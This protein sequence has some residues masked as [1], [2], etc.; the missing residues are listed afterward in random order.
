MKIHWR[1]AKKALISHRE[2]YIPFILVSML[3]VAICEIFWSMTQ[4]SSLKQ[5]AAGTNASYIILL[6]AIFVTVLSVIFLF[7]INRFLMKR[8][9]KELALY[10]MLGLTKGDLRLVVLYEI[11]ILWAMVVV[12][13][14][15]VGLVL[16]KLFF[17]ILTFFL[18]TTTIVEQFSLNSLILVTVIFSGIFSILF[19]SD[20]KSLYQVQPANLWNQSE[21][22]EPEPKSNWLLGVSSLLFLAVGYW[23]AVKTSP[24]AEAMVQFVL[25]MILVIIGIYGLFIA[26]SIV[27]LKLLKKN[28]KFYYQPKHFISV[29]GTL[30]RMKQNGASLASICLLCTTI[31]VALV[32]SVSLYV[33]KE[34][35]IN[36]SAPYDLMMTQSK[37][38]SATEQKVMQQVVKKQD[39]KISKPKQMMMTVPQAVIVKNHHIFPSSMTAPSATHQLSTLTLAEYNNLS[40][41]HYQLQPNQILVYTDDGKKVA[42]QLTLNGR[43]Y[44][45]KMIPQ[46]AMQFNYQNSIYKSLF[47]VAA[48]RQ[49]AQ[50]IN[51]QPW[52]YVQGQNL[53]GNSKRVLHASKLVTTAL[54]LTAEQYTS[55]PELEGFWNSLVGSILFVGGLISLSM[56]L[57]TGA[58]IYYKQLSEGYADR[59]RFQIMQEVGLSKQETAQ[60]IRSQVLLLFM[61]PIIGAIINLAFALPAIKSILA[62]FSIY[63][64][65]ILLAVSITTLVLLIIY[66]LIVYA[67][68][69]RAYTKI[70]N[71]K[72]MSIE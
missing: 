45:T 11:L 41:K 36:R 31:L 63:N 21:Q 7:Y 60:T 44:R 56:I 3:L 24:N 49:V 55:K 62:V 15:I 32:G 37:P 72:T 42:Q 35:M 6:G 47:I 19:M 2:L 68:T 30:Y 27:I 34:K 16:S 18:Q 59:Q 8:Q 69:T 52:L 40:R 5:T 25:A 20:F 38:F 23:I 22:P 51:H 67:L 26:S 65:L 50:Q 71:T 14:L 17:L 43:Q 58:L 10:N 66:Y 39:V 4:N 70:V 53:A 29:S 57:L 61:L 28:R 1:L 54:H 48:N 13:G 12:L 9:L 33:G 46:F 64:V